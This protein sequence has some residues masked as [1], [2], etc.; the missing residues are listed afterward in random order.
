MN[1]NIN[2]SVSIWR[3]E[4]ESQFST[5]DKNIETQ[6]CIIG[7]GIAGLSIAYALLK[8]GKKVTVIESKQIGFN[9]TGN[10]SAHLSNAL[11]DRYFNI[12]SMHGKNAA[13][14]AAESHTEAINWIENVV[15]EEKIDCEFTRV[16]GFLFTNSKNKSELNKELDAAKEAGLKVSLREDPKLGTVLV[17]E[18]QARFHPIKYLNGLA[19]AVIK[20]GGK[21]Y[22][23]SH[24]EKV[25]FKKHLITLS[26][27]VQIRA[28]QIVTA[29][30]APMFSSLK[31]HFKLNP[32][33]SYMI[34][35][36]VPKDTIG[37]QLM[38]DTDEP[39]H[40]VRS[41]TLDDQHDI[42]L[43]GGEDHRVG[44]EADG[45]PY[46][47][48]EKWTNKYF[49]VAEYPIVF[50][51]SGQILE[52]IDY[53]AYIGRN[54]KSSNAYMVSGDSGNGL[55]HG[56]IAAILITDLISDKRNKYT[57]LYNP[58]RLPFRAI[59]NLLSNVLASNKAYAK[60]VLP[61]MGELPNKGEGKIVQNGLEKIAVY[62]DENNNVKKCSGIC[63]HLGAVL[64]F[65]SIAKTWD[66]GAHGSRF[67]LDGNIL[68]GPASSKLK[69]KHHY[70]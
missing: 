57:K 9:E 55:T 28:S 2:E 66:C 70:N 29:T 27:K 46:L 44:E 50:F 17:F 48:L 53:L 11:D 59:K 6:I 7:G 32:Q 40:Y 37:K 23:H 45:N 15:K 65:N 3:Q 5:L 1:K 25:D 62:R 58:N 22:E 34:G 26:N 31:M 24:V 33:R 63:P 47:N 18:D 61:Q 38:W 16:P 36:K 49:N 52:P 69:C 35:I 30:N 10:T 42:L 39:Y 41:Q 67:D 21:I 54:P 14:L 13:R 4:C 60:Y 64:K 19:K 51:W 43:V 56:T 68:N 20:A 12:A 8:K